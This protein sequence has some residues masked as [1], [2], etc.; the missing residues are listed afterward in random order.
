MN[1]AQ[2]HR[3]STTYYPAGNRPHLFLVRE[4]AP[5]YEPEAAPS[6]G[7][8]QTAAP[9]SS[10]VSEAVE[11]LPIEAEVFPAIK[12]DEAGPASEPD[13]SLDPDDELEE[14]GDRCITAYMQADALQYQAM[15]LLVEFHRREGWK[16]TPHP[17]TA[18]WLAW[19]LGIHLHTAQ[20]RL[21]T[22]L[23]LEQLPLT[24][25]AMAEGQLSYAK[26]RTLTRAATP[27]NEAFLVE[28]AKAGSAANLDRLISGWKLLDR[29]DEVTAEVIRHR[30]R[31]FSAFVDAD[32]MVVVRGRLDPEVGAVFMR[33]VEAATDALYRDEWQRAK[34]REAEARKA[35]GMDADDGNAKG[36]K[37]WEQGK[38]KGTG[39]GCGCEGR[40]EDEEDGDAGLSLTAE[41]RALERSSRAVAD[42]ELGEATPA[43]R[44]ADAVGLLAERS[45]AAGFGVAVV[46]HSR[47]H[48]VLPAGSGGERPESGSEKEAGT[49]AD[50]NATSGTSATSLPAG[51]GGED[52]ADTGNARNLLPAGSGGE[53]VQVHAHAQTHSCG[54][55]C[56]H[57][58]EPAPTPPPPPISGTRAERFM[59]ML[60]VDEAT[61]SEHGEPGLSEL[62]DGTR[63]S[64]ETARRLSCDCCMVEIYRGPDGEV[65]GAGKRKRTVSPQVRR[66]LEARDRGCRFPGCGA[67]FT[68]AHHVVHHKDGGEAT[69]ENCMLLCRIH[70]WC[71][72]EGGVKVWMDRNGQAVFF[73]RKGKAFA[74][75]PPRKL[76]PPK[77]PGGKAFEAPEVDA[78]AS[79]PKYNFDRD[80]PWEEE[81]RAREALDP[82]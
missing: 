39:C 32:G 67:R 5:E 56:G 8:E 23:A 48:G 70:H 64:A 77:R 14:L 13:T 9:E 28:H 27:D 69:L 22:A 72:H 76:P 35:E 81:A 61:L 44:R 30:Q 66:A 71:V 80:I 63:V 75:A 45:L 68:E 42:A 57:D 12:P 37:K 10:S 62:Q 20:E 3:Y 50:S 21:R 19:R 29:R 31:R 43:Q 59:V 65:T 24:S 33:A 46:R 79:A 40:D 25:E 41:C 74:G 15:V 17:S 53:D 49:E 11:L 4:A 55:G 34:E 6:L 7:A 26:V 73:T 52:T 2:D 1:T 78:W 54:C 36:T 82:A 60:H 58:H 16:H 47:A 51:S 38:G 18:R